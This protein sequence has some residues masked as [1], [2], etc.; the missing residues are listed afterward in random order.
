[1]IL[2]GVDSKGRLSEKIGAHRDN[3]TDAL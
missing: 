2:E 3:Y 1:L